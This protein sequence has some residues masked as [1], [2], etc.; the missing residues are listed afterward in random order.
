MEKRSVKELIAVVGFC[1]LFVAALLVLKAAVTEV[2]WTQANEL[3]WQYAM[4]FVGIIGGAVTLGAW[5]SKD[6]G[7]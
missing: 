2:P 1:A 4:M 5:L 7:Y 6:Q 3:L